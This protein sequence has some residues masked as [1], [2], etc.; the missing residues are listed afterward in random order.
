M[1]AFRLDIASF[2]DQVY[3]VFAYFKEI[4]DLFI[5]RPVFFFLFQKL[6]PCL[7]RDQNLAPGLDR[8]H[9]QDRNLDPDLNLDP[10][11]ILQHCK[12][13]CHGP[14]VVSLGWRDQYQTT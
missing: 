2:N 6:V 12:M 13:L 8:N 4:S 11:R 10:V 5:A 3:I 14:E 7:D 9:Y 1:F